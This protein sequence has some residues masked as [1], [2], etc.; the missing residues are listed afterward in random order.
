[1]QGMHIRTAGSLTGSGV[2]LAAGMPAVIWPTQ[3]WVAESLFALGILIIV[4][5]WLWWF[6]SNFRVV[7]PRRRERHQPLI[8]GYRL[9]VDAPERSRLTE[10]IKK[11]D[12]ECD[13][14]KLVASR[15][16]IRRFLDFLR[17]D[18]ERIGVYHRFQSMTETIDDESRR[19]GAGKFDG[20]LL[21]ELGAE[22]QRLAANC[23][24][25]K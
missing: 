4:G 22:E 3:I 11:V 25:G 8:D 6:F 5:S 16:V 21:R 2:A 13:N 12:M 23:S 9:I 15:D 17:H 10:L 18:A 14:R 20:A 19:K 1:M 24:R 7:V